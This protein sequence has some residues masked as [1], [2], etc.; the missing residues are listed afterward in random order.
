MSVVTFE[1][2]RVELQTGE[3]VLSGLERAGQRIPNSCRSGV[4]QS[5]LMQAIAGEVPPQ[6]QRGLKQS[7]ALQGYFLSC[8]CQP[9]GDLRVALPTSVMPGFATRVTYKGQ[10]AAEV[11]VLRLE[12]PSGF[13]CRSGQY[14]NLEVEQ[15]VRSYSVASVPMRDGHIEL[16]VRRV[17]GG[18]VSNWLH[19]HCEVGTGCTIRGP[20]GDCFYIPSETRDFPMV[21]AGTGTGLAPL[22]GIVRDALHQGHQGPITL[23][24]GVRDRS[25]LYHGDKLSELAA[26]HPNFTYLQ[27]VWTE[28]ES[29]DISALL[30]Q[31]FAQYVANAT[32]VFLCGAPDLVKSMKRQVFL[33]GAASSHIHA[34]PFVVA[35]APVAA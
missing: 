10:V 9:A 13:E 32:R 15:L 18:R 8:Q 2:C 31:R 26:A 24:H 22:E 30:K 19:D 11:M 23:I 3:T 29:G 7:L 34:D 20:L 1:E 17:P 4:C 12:V 6:S 16:H 27:A 35:P 28:G 21:L 5:C 33:A 14:V 25:G